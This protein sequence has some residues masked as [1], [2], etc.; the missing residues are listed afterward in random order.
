MAVSGTNI[1]RAH[2]LQSSGIVCIDG[3]SNRGILRQVHSDVAGLKLEQ[4]TAPNASDHDAIN[5][6]ALE[7]SQRLTHSVS[8]VRTCV[9]YHLTSFGIAVYNQEERRRTEVRAYAAIEAIVL[10]NRNTNLHENLQMG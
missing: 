4:R 2:R 9:G 6:S 5:F 3:L 1:C 8:V 7:K 10:L